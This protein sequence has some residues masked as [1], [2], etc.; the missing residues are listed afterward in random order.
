MFCF[1]NRK[2]FLATFINLVV[3]MYVEDLDYLFYIGDRLFKSVMFFR[4]FIPEY[5]LV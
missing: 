5:K 3:Y 4:E 2:C 1:L